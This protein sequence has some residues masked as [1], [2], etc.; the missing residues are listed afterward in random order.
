VDRPPLWIKITGGI[1]A[2]VWRLPLS[3][4]VKTLLSGSIYRNPPMSAGRVVETL[5]ALERTDVVVCCMGGWGVDALV[6][7]QSR[8]HHDLDLIVE[9]Q[10]W[11]AALEALASLGYEKWYEQFSEEDDNPLSDRIVVRDAAMRVVDVHPV[12]LDAADFVIVSGS[13]SGHPVRCI[14]AEQQFHSHQGFRKRLLH[15]R[16]TQRSNKEIARRVLETESEQSG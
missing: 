8:K 9:R 15:E 1:N 16:R 2:V 7:E 10:S 3:H 13:I 5:E 4:R 6:G 11:E 14:S 12:D